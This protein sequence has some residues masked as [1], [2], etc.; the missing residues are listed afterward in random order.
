MKATYLVRFDDI[1]PTMNWTVWSQLEAVLARYEVK[2]LLAV[3]PDN[4]DPKLQVEPAR[5][6]FWAWARQKQ[7]EGWSIGMHGY[8]HV[9]ETCS[10][11][12]LGIHRRSEFAGLPVHRQK[13]KLQRA[14]EIFHANG[15]HPEVF[16]AP[17][18]SFDIGTLEALVELGIEIVSDGFFLFPQ[19]RW[20]VLWIPQQMWRW[21]GMPAGVWT[22]AYHHNRMTA[23]QINQFAKDIH[24]F[25]SRIA[26]FSEVVRRYRACGQAGIIS[27]SFA[28]AWRLA[29]LAKLRLKRYA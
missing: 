11:G 9:Y 7:R 27:L 16:V 10:G 8:Q 23:E 17:S 15:I 28:Q 3:V 20:G 29:L 12:L 25:A 26:S 2:P 19:K 21:Y 13:E 1:C 22:V 14:L 5:V 18:H 4:R 24:R 6:D